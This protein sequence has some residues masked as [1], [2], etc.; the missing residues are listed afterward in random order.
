MAFEYTIRF[1]GL[2][3]ETRERILGVVLTVDETATLGNLVGGFYFKSERNPMLIL[4]AFSNE[5]FD[6]EDFESF[7][8]ASA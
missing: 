4:E 1:E 6:Y 8:F 3:K 5:G 2:N 7:T